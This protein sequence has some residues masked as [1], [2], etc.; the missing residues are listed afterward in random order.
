MTC[1]A[2]L[3]RIFHAHSSHV[4]NAWCWMIVLDVCFVWPQ[5]CSLAK[6]IF[7][8]KML[9]AFNM[10]ISPMNVG[11][12]F[13]ATIVKFDDVCSTTIVFSSTLRKQTCKEARNHMGRVYYLLSVV[14]W[15]LLLSL[16]A[17]N[18]QQVHWQV[19]FPVQHDVGP[20]MSTFM[21]P[22]YQSRLLL[23]ER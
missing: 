10:S 9:I 15:Q 22:S 13:L 3:C 4:A 2:T 16:T 7:V 6:F 12:L 14:M 23:Q 8:I 19:I 11:G 18:S 20:L 17:V 5:G 21:M 1:V